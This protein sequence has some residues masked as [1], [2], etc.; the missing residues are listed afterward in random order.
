[1][2]LFHDRLKRQ[3]LPKRPPAISRRH[4]QHPR[5]PQLSASRGTNT[6]ADARTTTRGVTHTGVCDANY[7]SCVYCPTRTDI[8]A[9]TPSSPWSRR[10]NHR[11]FRCRRKKT[12][13]IFNRIPPGGHPL[14]I[15]FL[16]RPLCLRVLSKI[17]C[18][19]SGALAP[20][21]YRRSSVVAPVMC[22]HK[23]IKSWMAAHPRMHP[24]I[25]QYQRLH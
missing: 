23:S 15:R 1:M 24:D 21:Y 7:E 9:H 19:P 22:R 16:T 10:L 14:S 12:R 18:H 20:L 25:L 5:T 17:L 13:I 11:L 8:P 3:Q 2:P 4:A 6:G